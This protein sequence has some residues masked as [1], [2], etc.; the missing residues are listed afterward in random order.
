MRTFSV[1]RGKAVPLDR[2]NVDT[3]QIIPAKHLKRIERT[4]YGEFAFEAWRKNPEFVLNDPSHLGAR[5]LLTRENF[6]SGS[7]REHA[8]WA[9]TGLGIEALIGVDFA[10]IFKNNCFQSGVLTIERPSEE[11]DFLMQLVTE[12]PETEIVVDLPAQTISVA[13]RSWSR[14]FDIDP[15]RKYRLL[16][17]LDDISMTLEYEADIEAY[18]RRRQPWMSG[19]GAQ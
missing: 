2:A 4:G 5:I 18:E 9:L 15:F 7:S 1:V 19:A 12:S 8:V 10:D 11:I 3:D 17:G 6:G 14:D 16:R 13:N